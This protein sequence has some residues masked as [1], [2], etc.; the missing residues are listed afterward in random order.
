MAA[1]GDE[2]QMIDADLPGFFHDADGA[3]ARGQRQTLAL[4]RLRLLSAII[5][6]LGGALT[7]KAGK[8]DLW[9]VVSMAGFLAALYA[10]VRLWNLKPE[11]DWKSGRAVAEAIKSLAW[12]FSV[13]GNPFPH[14]LP[15]ARQELAAQTADVVRKNGQNLAMDSANPSATPQMTELRGRPFEERRRQYIECRVRDQKIW[16]SKKSRSNKD[17]ASLW[18]GALILGELLAI[19]LA[20]G[21]AVGFW[22]VDIS[23]V[24]AAAVAGGAA[25]L[26]VKQHETLRLS[27]GAAATNLALQEERLADA[28]EREWAAMVADTE[29]AISREHAAWLASRPTTT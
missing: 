22:D 16:Y 8:I 24:M 18:R 15:K 27:Y 20:G 7:W 1:E 25:W 23:G 3:A 4:G 17:R 6:A 12:R 29:E 9:A 19:L 11:D 21:R 2:H 13:A 5:A 14:D 10:E 26:G 28:D